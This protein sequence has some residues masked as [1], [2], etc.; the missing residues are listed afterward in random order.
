MSAAP[1]PA[2]TAERERL[3]ALFARLCEIP[4]PYGH[5][6]AMADAVTAELCGMGL[7]VTEDDTAPRSGAECGNLLARVPAPPGARSVCL[8]AHLDTV[9]QAGP[10]EVVREDG[11]F[12]NR[13]E[14]ILGAD[15]KAAVAVFLEAARRYAG[16]EAA[17][18]G[19]ELLFTGAEE[20]ALCGAKEFDLGRLEADLGFIFDHATPIGGVIVAAPTHFEV[21]AEFSGRPAHAGIRP[22]DGRS[23]IVAATRAVDHMALGRLDE[24]TTANVGVIRG[25]TAANVVAEH[26]RVELE[27]RSLDTAKATRSV[28]RLVDAITWAAGTTETDVETDVE[29]RFR[30][31][32]VPRTAPVVRVAAAA[33]EDLGFEPDYIATGGGSDANAFCAAGA[34]FLNLANGT[35]ANHTAEERVTVEALD[36]ALE[37]THRLLARSAEVE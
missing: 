20:D 23:A 26:C 27:T 36:T 12:V 5:E 2:A 3:H 14:E 33:L 25:G 34:S 1:R 30:G 35:E 28:E 19:I 9:P 4:S 8:C 18:V 17:P 10:I 29:E 13:H 22:E 7:E 32:R 21:I 6:R 15:N 31:Y 11:A 24:E 37:L 16:G